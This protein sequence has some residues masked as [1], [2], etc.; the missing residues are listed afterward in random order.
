MLVVSLNPHCPAKFLYSCSIKL[1]STVTVDLFHL[2]ILWYNRCMGRNHIFTTHWWQQSEYYKLW[3]IIT[4]CEV[5]ISLTDQ[6]VHS[7]LLQVLNGNSIGMAGSFCCDLT[8]YAVFYIPSDLLLYTRPVRLCFSL[9]YILDIPGLPFC[10]ESIHDFLMLGG[11]SNLPIYAMQPS[12]MLRSPLM[13]QYL[14]R[15][16]STSL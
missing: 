11:I 6:M 9:S 5:T 14:L 1:F 8:G 2:T 4:G 16:G 13:T 15:V 10:N 7:F 3:V 12:S